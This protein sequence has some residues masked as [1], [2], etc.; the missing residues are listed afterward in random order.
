MEGVC[1]MAGAGFDFKEVA[2]LQK[3][4]EAIERGKDAFYRDCAREL[5]A[6]LLSKVA[7]R[8]P[9]GRAPK[10]DGSKTVKVMGSSGKSRTFLSPQA[11]AWSGYV[12]GNLR[13]N[14]TVGEIQKEGGAYRIEVFNPTE[15][16][17]YVEY[18]HRQEPG[19]YVPAIGKRLKKGWI[20]GKFMLAISEKEINALA[21]K[22]VEKK[23]EEMIREVFDA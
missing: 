18:G 12:G 13:R 9:V 22:L 6:R 15:Y 19:R 1:L 23:L 21:P 14:W 11:A 16:A 17:S 20:Q 8:T 5:A 3:Q 4:A 7:R 10:I 2:K